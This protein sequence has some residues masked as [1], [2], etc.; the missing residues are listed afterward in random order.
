MP[1]VGFEHREG[2]LRIILGTDVRNLAAPLIQGALTPL[3]E[4]HGLSQSDIRFWVAHPG[5]RKVI[6]N[7][8]KALDLTDAQLGSRALF[9]VSM[10]TCRRPRCSSSWTKSC[11]PAIRAPATGAS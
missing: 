8:Q 9:C 3:L 4:R 5:G 10:A 1:T 11:A 2:K 7:V 6:D